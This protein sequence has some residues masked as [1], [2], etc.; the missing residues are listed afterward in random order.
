MNENLDRSL[1]INYFREFTKPN[2]SR[3]TRLEVFGENGAQ[4]EECYV[5]TLTTPSADSAHSMEQDLFREVRSEKLCVC[6][7]VLIWTPTQIA[8][9]PL[10]IKGLFAVVDPDN[11][12]SPEN[13]RHNRCSPI[14][15]RQGC[16][17]GE[18]YENRVHSLSD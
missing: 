7:N 6:R 14:V 9:F 3:R 15:G 10:M 8:E 12:E 4:V 11:R 1:W 2:Q 18:P 5:S 16:D 13:F 17:P